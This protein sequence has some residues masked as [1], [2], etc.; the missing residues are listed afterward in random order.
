[1]EKEAT[2]ENLDVDRD[3]L[4]LEKKKQ[5]GEKELIHF[6]SVCCHQRGAIQ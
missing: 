6:L 4:K 5:V 1:M 2:G 3:C